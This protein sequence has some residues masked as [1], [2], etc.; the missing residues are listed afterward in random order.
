MKNNVKE[1]RESKL[2]TQ[3]QLAQMMG[4]QTQTISNI[5]NS[6]HRPRAITVRKLVIALGVPAEQLFSDEADEVPAA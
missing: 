3:S 4:V 5:E 2:M 6:R 1:I